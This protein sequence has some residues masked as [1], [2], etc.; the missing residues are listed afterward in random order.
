[1]KDFYNGFLV[2]VGVSGPGCAFYFLGYE[3]GKSIFLKATGFDQKEHKYA[4]GLFGGVLAEILHALVCQP[5]ELM[6]QQL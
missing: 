1:M 3:T 5:A 6:K 4:Q 2:Q